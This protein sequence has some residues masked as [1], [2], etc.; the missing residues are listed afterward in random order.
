MAAVLRRDFAQKMRDLRLD[1]GGRVSG[2]LVLMSPA[3]I[4]VQGWRAGTR[5]Q[6]S[7]LCC[8]RL[9]AGVAPASTNAF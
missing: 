9:L 6:D 2:W 7:H 3:S 1:D 5:Q 4:V 8:T